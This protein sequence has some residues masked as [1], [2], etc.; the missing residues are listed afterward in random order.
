[1]HYLLVVAK[2]PVQTKGRSQ[3]R[4]MVLLPVLE[5]REIMTVVDHRVPPDHPMV[6]GHQV[7]TM[8]G[9]QKTNQLM[10]GLQ[11]VL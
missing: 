5:R 9:N 4:V 1:L 2:G 6:I 8:Y 3:H 11:V 7:S 10:D